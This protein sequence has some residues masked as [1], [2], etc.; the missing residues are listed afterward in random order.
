MNALAAILEVTQLPASIAFLTWHAG[1][2]S[3]FGP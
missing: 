3:D 2:I 1:A